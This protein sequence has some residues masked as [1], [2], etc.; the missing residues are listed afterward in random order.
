MCKA[1]DVHRPFEHPQCITKQLVIRTLYALQAV[2]PAADSDPSD[3]EVQAGATTE[4]PAAQREDA[5]ESD[6]E[7]SGFKK[8]G[9]RKL[10]EGN[11]PPKIAA[12][13]SSL[14]AEAEEAQKPRGRKVCLWH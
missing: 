7:P 2:S 4:K 13:P 5:D 11:A 10:A 12:E 8:R 9:L 14:G 1:A 3:V 6:Y